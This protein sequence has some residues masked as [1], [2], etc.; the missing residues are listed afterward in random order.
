[1]KT[2]FKKEP[3][4]ITMAG[5][6]CFVGLAMF[7][8]F[9]LKDSIAQ[10]DAVSYIRMAQE[11]VKGNFS[12]LL[13]S[14][15]SPLFSILLSPLL[16]FNIDPLL[17]LKLVQTLIA[18]AL[19][20]HSNQYLDR[21]FVYG[22][23]R[24]LFQLAFALPILSFAFRY[25]TPDLLFLF[26]SLKFIYYF[27]FSAVHALRYSI[28][29]AIAL[30][31]CKSVALVFLPMFLIIHYAL[32]SRKNRNKS[33]LKF[34]M[35]VS[36]F[37]VFYIA[38]VSIAQKQL[39]IPGA[40][41]YNFSLL[42]PGKYSLQDGTLKHP[43]HEGQLFFPNGAYHLSIWE[44][45]TAIPQTN[46]SPFESREYF[47]HFL[48][49]IKLNI[50][51]FYYL[52]FSNNVG[53][54]FL[55]F[56]CLLL[57]NG[58][59]VLLKQNALLLN[60]LLSSVALLAVYGSIFLSYRYIWLLFFSS[61]FIMMAY[62]SILRRKK[63]FRLITL[64]MLL[65][66]ML[67]MNKNALKELISGQQKESSISEMMELIVN[68]VAVLK[69]SNN[70][71]QSWLNFCRMG[72]QENSV[73]ESFISIPSSEINI[74]K[75]LL[76]SLY[77]QRT[78]YGACKDY[79]ESNLR[80]AVSKFHPTEIHSEFPLDDRLATELKLYAKPINRSDWYIYIR[81]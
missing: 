12:A 73:K 46:W 19:F 71:D 62:S 80:T 34:I 2:G 10:S 47:V 36:F 69:Q 74:R 31:L 49:V 18:L 25:S 65:F 4:I 64:F 24:I 39:T 35:C 15:W 53:F 14:Y 70:E 27:S 40:A 55:F 68:P 66:S 9:H 37:V 33:I 45:P 8:L 5:P 79:T 20:F 17:S 23:N 59:F 43:L 54:F 63:T 44:T 6:I 76:Y 21:F 60:L 52:Y 51:S 72:S 22:Y 41:G 75:S 67:I 26:L 30:V 57:L 13:N 81:K 11:T 32:S 78:Y 3:A 1:M 58:F 77:T 56:L 61:L 48:G 38:L 29:Y 16:Y 50:Q 28:V 42:H 7:F